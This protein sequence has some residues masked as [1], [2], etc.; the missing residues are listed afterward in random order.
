MLFQPPPTWGVKLNSMAEGMGADALSTP[1][2][3]GSETNSMAEGMGADAAFNPHL[4]G[5]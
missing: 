2:Y 3:V 4:R 5:E 1:T